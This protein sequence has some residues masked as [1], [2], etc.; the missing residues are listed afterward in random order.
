V[1][2]AGTGQLH[3]FPPAEPGKDPEGRKHPLVLC[4]HDISMILAL[5]CEMPETVSATGGNYLHRQ[6]ADV[7]TTHLEFSSGLRA[8]IFVSWLH[9]YKEQKLVV[10]GD[11][12]MAVFD[13]TLVWPDKLLLYAHKIKWHNNVSV[14][15]KGEPERVEISE[16]EPL[17]MECEH[18]LDSFTNGNR[19]QI[20][21]EEGL[22]VLKILNAAQRSLNTNGCTIDLKQSRCPKG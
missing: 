4:P 19:P 8:H 12:K 2:G 14:P 21:G 3:L 13:D 10:V 1:R 11:K 20:D 7:T 6:I 15:E 17:R 16:A 9:P 5:A 18:F 22:R